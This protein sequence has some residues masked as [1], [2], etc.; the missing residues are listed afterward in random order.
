GTTWLL[1]FDGYV[2]AGPGVGGNG[3]VVTCSTAAV[4]MG[5]VFGSR[6]TALGNCGIPNAEVRSPK[7]A[8][9]QGVM[10][11]IVTPVSTSR[12]RSSD[13]WSKVSLAIPPPCVH[14]ETIR[15]GTRNPAPIGQLG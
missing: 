10:L 15:H 1:L 9:R 2:P 13:V 7:V 3:S 6:R 4:T 11:G 5:S 12:T 8:R 14:G